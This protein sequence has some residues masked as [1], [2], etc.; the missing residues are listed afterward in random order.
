MFDGDKHYGFIAFQYIHQN[1]LKALLVSKM[2]QWKYSSFADYA[3]LRNGT[4][5]DKELAWELIGFDKN[6]FAKESYRVIN[7]E[8]VQKI[9][10][11]MVGTP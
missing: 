3:G 2:E 1:P 5:C 6:N 9:F 4:L 7:E 8:L 10:C 11:K